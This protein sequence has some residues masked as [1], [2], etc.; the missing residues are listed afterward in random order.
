MPYTLAMFALWGVA[1]AL[2]GGVIGW[3]LRSVVGRG[4]GA[5]RKQADDEEVAG[6]RE[7]LAALEP[8]VA[9]RDRLRMEVADV[10]GSSAGALGFTP[11]ERPDLERAGITLGRDVDLDDLTIV[12]GIGT[13][14]AELCVASGITTWRQLAETDVETLRS[15]LAD[16]GSQFASHDPSSWPRQAGLLADGRWEAFTDLTRE[17][18]GGR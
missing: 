3:M 18:D 1:L 4:Q 10:R 12:E 7:Q 11:V 6:L 14:T 9:E 16:G 17:L 15:M 5:A 8:V 2:I 13:S